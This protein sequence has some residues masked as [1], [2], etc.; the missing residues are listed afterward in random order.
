[1]LQAHRVV[2]ATLRWSFGKGQLLI[3]GDVFD[4]GPNH[5]E[6][7]WLLYK[8]EAEAAKAGGMIE[9]LAAALR[10]TR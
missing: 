7:L 2:D 4:R 6:I 9:E 3:L 1:M 10:T 5:T 8:L